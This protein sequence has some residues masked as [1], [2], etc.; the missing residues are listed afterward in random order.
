M[1]YGTFGLL[2]FLDLMFEQFETRRQVRNK[3]N[4][5]FT[6]RKQIQAIETQI[7]EELHKSAK[8]SPAYDA[9]FTQHSDLLSMLVPQRKASM[10]QSSSALPQPQ[11]DPKQVSKYPQPQLQTACSIVFKGCAGVITEANSNTRDTQ[12]RLWDMQAAQN[13][14]EVK[15]GE[16]N[17]FK[18]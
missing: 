3:F 2:D 13:P 11:N 16:L 12:H 8:L 9:W 1:C 5:Y 4:Y 10:T 14:L 7:N 15:G 18:Q 6:I 17:V